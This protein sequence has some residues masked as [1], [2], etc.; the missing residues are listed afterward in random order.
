MLQTTCAKENA[1]GF[2]M[3]DMAQE[4]RLWF[5]F[6]NL[7]GSCE[8]FLLQLAGS[9]GK[10]VPNPTRVRRL[11]RFR[12]HNASIHDGSGLEAWIDN[13]DQFEAR[14]GRP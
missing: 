14:A 13:R 12:K 6:E 8:T 10:H 9:R 7:D 1:V 3:I 4:G 11:R 5:A 2:P